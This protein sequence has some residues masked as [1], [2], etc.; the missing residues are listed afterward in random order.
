MIAASITPMGAGNSRAKGPNEIAK[1]ITGRDYLSF[2]QVTTYQNC[3]LKWFF[4]YVE[5][6]KPES[7]A[8][9]LLLGSSIHAALQH[10]LER[11]LAV[12]TPATIDELMDVFRQKWT[13]E[14]RDTPIDYSREEN[15]QSQAEIARRML[16]AFL[17][18]SYSHPEGQTLGIEETLRVSLHPEIPDLVA[19]VDLIAAV[20]HELVITDFKTARSMWGR[21]PL[22]IMPRN[23]TC[24]GRLP[25]VSPRIW[26]FRSGCGSSC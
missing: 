21:T 15:A 8:A 14:A 10:H 24:T 6:A 20:D 12:E 25:N 11:Q 9:P 17:A 1:S 3:K 2:S 16:E 7:I 26:S 19:K 22:K 5:S 23:S 18:T 4:T 13:A